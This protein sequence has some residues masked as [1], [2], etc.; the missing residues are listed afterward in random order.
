MSQRLQ[1]ILGIIALIGSIFGAYRFI[2]GRYA[3]AEEVRQIEQ[4]LDY[5]I[6]SDRYHAVEERMW[7]L[8]D[9]FP[10]EK[11]MPE[12]IREEYR[13]LKSEKE[14]IQEKLKGIK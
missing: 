14:I 3:Q 1:F 10:D 12:T 11:K 4:R 6:D 2:D 13:K 9:R 8:E 7:K 5:K